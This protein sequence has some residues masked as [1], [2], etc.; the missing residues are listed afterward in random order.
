M[1]VQRR[2]VYKSRPPEWTSV[3]VIQQACDEF[4][5]LRQEGARRRKGSLGAASADIGHHSVCVLVESLNILFVSLNDSR[6]RLWCV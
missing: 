6:S 1:S 2:P 4:V 5:E 3:H